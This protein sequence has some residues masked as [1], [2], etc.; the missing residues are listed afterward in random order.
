[1]LEDLGWRLHRIWS[2]DWFRNPRKEIEVLKEAIDAA[3]AR[4]KARG[5]KHSERLDATA[6]LTYPGE[7]TSAGIETATPPEVAAAEAASPGAP[8]WPNHAQANLPLEPPPGSDLFTAATRAAAEPTVALGSKVK[9]ENI[10]NGG[11]KLAF[12][13]VKGEN[14]L[15]EGKIGIHTPLGQALLDA[16]MGDEVEY[17]VGSHINK[18]RVRE[19]R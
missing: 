12:T 13:L 10:T 11:T 3:F 5:V 6:L 4:A 2:T 15:D 1:M 18:V 9:I 16:Q 14:A 7:D 17:Q 8:A 19:I